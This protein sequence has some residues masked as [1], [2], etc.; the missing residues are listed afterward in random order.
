MNSLR[1][2]MNSRRNPWKSLKNPMNS[3]RIPM[4]NL[5]NPVSSSRNP[6]IVLGMLLIVKGILIILLGILLL[7]LGM[8]SIA[9]GNSYNTLRNPTDSFRNHTKSLGN[10]INSLRDP[11]TY[12]RY[13]KVFRILS[14]LESNTNPKRLSI[15]WN[16]GRI[17]PFNIPFSFWY[18][19]ERIRYLRDLRLREAYERET[20]NGETTFVDFPY[21]GGRYLPNYLDKI[22]IKYQT[23]QAIV[24]KFNVMF[25]RIRRKEECPRHSEVS[26]PY[27]SLFM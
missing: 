3:R 27:L 17:P 10:P 15:N 23:M 24:E 18:D 20:D 7:V 25:G 14:N 8:L 16:S 1:N 13:K 5:R 6:M 9:L 19:E 4:N 21:N 26:L 22:W 11:N 12:R 2:S